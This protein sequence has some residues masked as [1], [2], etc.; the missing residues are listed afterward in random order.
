[1]SS[2]REVYFITHPDVRVDPRQPVPNW[3]LSERGLARMRAALSLPWVSTLT[4]VY[5][6][7]EQKAREGAQLLA[8]RTGQP[9]QVRPELGEVDRSA[10]GYLP[11]AEHEA[12]AD[13]MFAQPALS[14]RGWETAR[15]AQARIVSAVQTLVAADASSGAIAVVSH[16]AVGAF[17]LCHL[18]ELTIERRHDQ[19]GAGGG[20]Y[21]YFSYPPGR[22]LD[23]WRPIDPA[24]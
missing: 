23:G 6:S 9:V 5:S 24:P 18:A 21:F 13:E 14:A 12:A 3:S 10:T 2:S 17:L 19:P 22:L 20:N 4:A 1:M 16:G 11:H 8:E 15:H 7:A